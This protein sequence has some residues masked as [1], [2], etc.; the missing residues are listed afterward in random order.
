MSDL[1]KYKLPMDE[2]PR[3]IKK[4]IKKNI[5]ELEF[6]G[7]EKAYKVHKRQYLKME[8]TEIRTKKC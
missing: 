7:F 4:S 2:L 5:Q 1:N 8:Y 6:P 3:D